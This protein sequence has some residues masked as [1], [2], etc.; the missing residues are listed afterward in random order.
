MNQINGDFNNQLRKVVLSKDVVPGTLERRVEAFGDKG[1]PLVRGMF[2][3]FVIIS[4]YGG[5]KKPRKG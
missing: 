2:D 5:L 3:E 1:D 4:D